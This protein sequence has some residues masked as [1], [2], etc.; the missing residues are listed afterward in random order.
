[1]L[2][3]T[4]NNVAPA[5]WRTLRY[6]LPSAFIDSL[7]AHRTGPKAQHSSQFFYKPLLDLEATR[8]TGRSLQTPDLL[9]VQVCDAVVRRQFQVRDNDHFCSQQADRGSA[10][11]RTSGIL[12]LQSRLNSR[13][14]N[15]LRIA[16]SLGVHSFGRKSGIDRPSLFLPCRASHK[17]FSHSLRL[18]IAGQGHDT[19]CMA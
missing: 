18:A 9:F 5:V 1:M 8:T 15:P 12:Y 17:F 13:P 19:P 10:L 14:S 7:L 6:R 3:L 2:H 11:I 4:R 16:P